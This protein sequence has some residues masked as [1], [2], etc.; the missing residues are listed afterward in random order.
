MFTF[1]QVG[2]LSTLYNTVSGHAAFAK[3]YELTP[4]LELLPN[5]LCFSHLFNDSAVICFK[6]SLFLS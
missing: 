4:F 2:L 6:L 3:D 5:D 1:T